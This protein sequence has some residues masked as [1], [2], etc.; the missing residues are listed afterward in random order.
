MAPQSSSS[1]LEPDFSG[2]RCGIRAANLCQSV[3][4]RACY[5]RYVPPL[6]DTLGRFLSFHPLDF[7]GRIDTVP[8]D[9]S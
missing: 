6:P 3:L 5:G 1:S 2:S 9:H 7:L 4:G 8:T